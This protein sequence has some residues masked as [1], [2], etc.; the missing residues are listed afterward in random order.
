[1]AAD[2]EESY[3]L[4]NEELEKVAAVYGAPGRALA[5]WH[6]PHRGLTGGHWSLIIF[7]SACKRQRIGSQRHSQSAQSTKSL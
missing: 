4:I 1:M 2:L 3:R 6:G 5:S 7:R